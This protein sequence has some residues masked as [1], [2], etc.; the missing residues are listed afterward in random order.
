[1]GSL[2]WV[3]GR[4]RNESSGFVIYIAGEHVISPEANMFDYYSLLH[5]Q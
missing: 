1:M 4:G 2:A 5:L 3:K